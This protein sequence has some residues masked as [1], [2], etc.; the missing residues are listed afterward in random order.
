MHPSDTAARPIPTAACYFPFLYEARF[1]LDGAPA[2][3][4]GAVAAACRR[5]F[6]SQCSLALTPASRCCCISQYGRGSTAK[7]LTSSSLS[8]ST[9]L[10][11]RVLRLQGTATNRNSDRNRNT[12]QGGSTLRFLVQHHR[13]DYRVPH[14]PCVTEETSVCGTA[15]TRRPFCGTALYVL[16]YH[17]TMHFKA[18]PMVLF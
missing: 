3:E 17:S 4:R 7:P 11:V 12:A 15:C 5:S 2:L 9:V 13:T 8:L 6:S 1:T 18:W 10:P 16:L 14:D